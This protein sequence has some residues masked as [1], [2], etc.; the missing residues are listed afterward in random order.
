MNHETSQNGRQAVAVGTMVLAVVAALAIGALRPAGGSSPATSPDWLQAV[1]TGQDH[2][3]PTDLARELMAATGDVAV[4][5]LRPAA[6]YAVWHLPGAHN[7]TVPQVCGEQGARLFAARPRLVVLYSNGPAHPGQAWVELRRQGRTNVVVLDGGLD[8]F[9]SRVLT[10]PSLRPDADEATARSEQ[11]SFAL[12]QAFF[13]GDRSPSPHAGW[14]TDPPRL[15]APTMVSTRWLAERL[16]QVAVVDVRPP[17]DHASLHLPG[18]VLVELGKIRVKHGDRDLQFVGDAEL[19]RYFGERGIGS[20]TPVVVYADD[21]LQDA[22]MTAVALLRLGH[23]A[24]A[25]LEGGILRWATEGRP[26]VSSATAVTPVVYTPRPGA[27]DFSRTTEEVAQ[28]QAS[29]R[30]IL[31]VRPPEFFRGEKSTEA[32]PGHIPGAV[33]RLFSQDFL[34]KADGQWLRPRA[35]IERE[36]AALGLK[37]D[38]E[39][40]VH[41]RTGHTASWSWFML[42]HLLGYDQARFYNGSW[43]EWAERADL[44][45]VTGE[46]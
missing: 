4:V 7:L 8:E 36:Y 9:K 19:A 15:A 31:D 13:R 35:E 12:V 20:D 45:A 30:S 37:P 28:A 24:L 18:A 34:R 42:R 11:A 2:I 27:D 26:L 46:R 17:R 10:P 33:N 1:E 40:V 29:G 3:S 6:E 38:Q 25:I 32:R 41:C 21:K 44:P 39:V 43:T 23:R 14:A 22:S 16:G 5:D